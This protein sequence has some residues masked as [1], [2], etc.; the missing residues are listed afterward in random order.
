MRNKI[1]VG[2]HMQM[3]KLQECM[4]LADFEVETQLRKIL[5][6][7]RLHLKKGGSWFKPTPL[8]GWFLMWV[9]LG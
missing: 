3:R 8:G 5:T 9:Q 1:K 2:P 7:L 6:R 4:W